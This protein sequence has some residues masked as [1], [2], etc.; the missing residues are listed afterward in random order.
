MSDR[1]FR[2]LV[3]NFLIELVVYGVLVVV[4]F[5]MV[6]RLMNAWLT[7]IFDQNLA[8]Y[9]FLALILV[10]GQGVLLDIVTSLLLDWLNL[11]RLE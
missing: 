11:E 1:N 4:Y 2:M 3:R 5:Y 6:L 9:A 10:L 8:L 7:Q